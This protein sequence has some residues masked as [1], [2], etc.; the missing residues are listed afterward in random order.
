[1]SLEDYGI[2]GGWTNNIGNMALTEGYKVKVSKNCQLILDGIPATFPLDITLKAGW[3]IMGYP[4]TQVLDGK[5]M[6]KQLIDRTTLIKVQDESG[7]AIEDY[8]I[9]G[10]WTNN[11][12]NFKPGEGYKIKVKADEILT[13]PNSSLPNVLQTQ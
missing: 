9:F 8:G 7:K 5:V 1:M 6:V 2:F 4:L 12:G 10:G 11:I 3:N 13:L